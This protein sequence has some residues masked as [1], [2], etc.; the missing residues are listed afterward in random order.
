[1]TNESL[2]YIEPLITSF[3]SVFDNR[4]DRVPDL[5]CLGSMF[6]PGAIIT[7]RDGDQLNVMS[8]DDFTAPRQTLLT[9]GTLV[10]FH[11]WEIEA[12]TFVD[13]GIATRISKYGKE[14]ALNGEPFSGLGMKSIQLVLTDKGWKIASVLWEDINS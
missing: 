5:S 4:D 13:N 8:L 9:N 12:Q 14:G 3:F 10:D 7:K 11:E 1:M 2:Q 6:V